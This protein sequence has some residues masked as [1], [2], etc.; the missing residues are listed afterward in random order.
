MG[1]VILSNMNIVGRKRV[2]LG[3]LLLGLGIFCTAAHAT[4]NRVTNELDAEVQRYQKEMNAKVAPLNQ[5]NPLSADYQKSQIP[6]ALEA[7]PTNE[8]LVRVQRALA[9]PV[10]QTYMRFFTN[11]VFG[12]A[13]EQILKSPQRMTLAYCEIGLFF[14]LFVFRAWRSSKIEAGQWMRS[15]WLRVW[16]ALAYV[17]IGSIA[18]PC[19][20]IGA[21]YINLVLLSYRT[22]MH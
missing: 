4:D 16:T 18:L 21:P 9:S 12:A 19:A 13:L 22:Y 6:N 7:V 20:L 15:L 5:L 10:A 17:S 2:H 14:F 1:R 11:P 8:N 3:L